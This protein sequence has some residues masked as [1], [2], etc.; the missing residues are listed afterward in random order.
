MPKTK[1]RRTRKKSLVTAIR[2]GDQEILAKRDAGNKEA[3]KAMKKPPIKAAFEELG[4]QT[5]KIVADKIGMDLHT[6]DEDKVPDT[7]EVK[8]CRAILKKYLPKFGPRLQDK[9]LALRKVDFID[10]DTILDICGEDGEKIPALYA[11]IQDENQRDKDG[12]K[13]VPEFDEDYLSRLEQRF[14]E[15]SP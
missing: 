10:P 7:E 13:V 2:E 4:D 8:M 9:K 6:P 11:V 3:A 14:I 5:G 15:I 1:V 12:M